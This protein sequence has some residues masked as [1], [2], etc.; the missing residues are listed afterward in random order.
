MGL[1]ITV[2]VKWVPNT[3]IVNIDPVTGTLIR[4]GIP[5]IINPHDLNAVEVALRLKD[6]YGGKV[7]ALSMAPLSAKAGLEFV[8]G[9][10]VDRAVLISDRAFAGADTL[11]TSYTL[12]KAIERLMPL[13]IIMF[14]QETIDSSTAHIGAQIASFLNLPYLYY[15][16][17][18]E[19]L[20]GGIRAKRRLEKRIEI[21]DLP[22]PCVLVT[23]MKSNEP[24]PVRLHYKLR[25]KLENLIEVWTND[26]LKLNSEYIGLKGS[27]TRVMKCIPTPSIPRKKQKLDGNDPKEAAKWL[28]EKILEEGI[29]I[30]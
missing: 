22:M 6:R 1:N 26:E 9:M 23:A 20:N 14:G 12:A 18:V 25:A 17:D 5:S 15:V 10:G 30:V 4:E 19:H 21:Y 7:T 8:L 27:P 11:A 13:D 2:C 16:T 28:L 24:R 29:K 3:Q